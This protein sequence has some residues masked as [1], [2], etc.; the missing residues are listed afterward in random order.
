MSH[1][2]KTTEFC[3]KAITFDSIEYPL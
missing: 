3:T 2:Y 1:Q